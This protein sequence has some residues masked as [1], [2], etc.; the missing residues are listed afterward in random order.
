[1][2]MSSSHGGSPSSHPFSKIGFW[3][4][5]IPDHLLRS[6]HCLPPPRPNAWRAWE[7]VGSHRFFLGKINREIGTWGS[8]SMM[9]G[10]MM[11]RTRRF[12]VNFQCDWTPNT[13]RISSDVKQE[14]GFGT[15][16]ALK[17]I[18][19]LNQWTWNWSIKMDRLCGL[20]SQRDYIDTASQKLSAKLGMME[21]C[22]PET[23]DLGWAEE[24]AYQQS[25]WQPGHVFIPP[26]ITDMK[27]NYLGPSRQTHDRNRS[28]RLVYTPNGIVHPISTVDGVKLHQPPS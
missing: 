19:G 14:I 21:H 26:T 18:N 4:S 20:L 8:G 25:D 16:L 27:H 9:D 7:V 22:N 17:W 23:I 1:M 10:E 13:G 11:V 24:F 12:F 5:G 15:R 28:W 2:D 6:R 3:T